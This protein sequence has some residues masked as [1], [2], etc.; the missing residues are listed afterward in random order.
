[1]ASYTDNAT[2]SS[3]NPD[4]NLD[5]FFKNSYQMITGIS[6]IHFS[7]SF[8]KA[9]FLLFN[10]FSTF[11][12]TIGLSLN[13][14]LKNLKIRNLFFFKAFFLI[15]FFILNGFLS[16]NN[17]GGAIRYMSSTIPIYTTF[18]FAVLPE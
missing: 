17:P 7:E 4:F 1:M 10:S 3:T 8:T 14:F 16:Q 18:I 6:I 2:F 5:S 13:Y 9:S 11:I 12:F 15:S